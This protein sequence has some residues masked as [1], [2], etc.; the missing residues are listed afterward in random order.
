MRP[1]LTPAD[2]RRALPPPAVGRGA[3][4]RVDV[5]QDV[6][7]P[8]PRLSD[9]RALDPD[10]YPRVMVPAASGIR[11]LVRPRTTRPAEVIAVPVADVR[12]GDHVGELNQAAV[13]GTAFEWNTCWEA[14][15]LRSK[16]L[17]ERLPAALAWLARDQ[18][19]AHLLTLPTDVWAASAVAPEPNRARPLAPSLPRYEPYAPLYHLLP[20]SALRA[21]GLPLLDRG[22]WPHTAFNTWRGTALPA[23][24]DY[25]VRR[26]VAHHLWRALQDVMPRGR[27]RVR[28]RG[29]LA[30]YAPDEPLR[31][32]AHSPEIWVP[33]L[34]AVI[35]ARLRSRAP[36]VVLTPEE[37]MLLAERRAAARPDEEVVPCCD[38]AYAWVGEE[39]A[40][41]V[42]RA[43]VETADRDGQLREWIAAVRANEVEEDYA[44][45]RSAGEGRDLGRRLLGTR[46]SDR[47]RNGLREVVIALNGPV[48]CDPA[49]Q[50]DE[51]ILLRHVCSLLTPDER[52]VV[53]LVYQGYSVTDV[54]KR[55]DYA[56]H[57]AVSKK[58]TRI[59][60]KLDRGR[61]S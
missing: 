59:R 47:A 43:V 42:T 50:L 22:D 15:P 53:H 44:E 49:A 11:V 18:V 30:A 40:A 37:Q 48:L 28:P 8:D 5:D 61:L 4:G 23:D 20:A 46:Q 1:L 34:H 56:N 39:D 6:D 16:L 26:A 17:G 57:S 3:P 38:T 7:V 54:A 52:T 12:T 10:L 2:L 35:E 41:E 25:R 31:V 13:V 51:E 29:G 14:G 24:A 19:H 9:E 60:A 32:L 21:A 27:G 58:L 55:L 36:R 33:A 45:G